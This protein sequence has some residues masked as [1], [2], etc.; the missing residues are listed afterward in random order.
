MKATVF[1]RKDHERIAELF[2]K[3]RSARNP[4]QNVLRAL[5]EQ[6]RREIYLHSAVETQIFYPALQNTTS[7]RA[8]ELVASAEHDHTQIDRELE[9]IVP[10]NHDKAAD[11][12][13]RLMDAVEAHFESEEQDM[14]AEARLNLSEQRLEELGLE[15]EDRRRLMTQLAA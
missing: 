3:Y 2:N 15:M 14:F 9:S 8:E 7:A 5:I 13:H 6:I 11:A 1:L 10:N 4:A 12:I